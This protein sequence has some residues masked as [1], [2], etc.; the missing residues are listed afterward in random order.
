MAGKLRIAIDCRI[1]SSQQGIGT[2]V[3]ALAKALSNSGRKDQE[4]TFIVREEMKN[5]LAPSIFGCC[6]LEGVPRS[7]LST[8]KA[9]LRWAAPLRYIWGKLH[10][11]FPSIATSD[12][13]VES[14]HFD[15]V[16]F[17]TPVAYL[18]TLP[19]IYQPHDL[20]HLH[21]PEFF[22]KAQ[23]AQRER[24]YRAFCDQAFYVCVQTE[25]T[26]LDVL[27]RYHLP[28]EKVAVI[29]WG[30][31][32]DAYEEPSPEDVQAC[33][34]KFNLPHL[35]FFYPAVTWPHKNHETIFRALH[36]LKS[37]SGLT[38]HVFFTGSS[39]AYSST[40]DKLARDLGISEQLHFLGFVTSTELQT[41]FRVATAMI[42]PS[43]FEGFGLPILEAFHAQLPVLCAKTS[44]L[45]EVAQDGA[46]YFDPDSPA[47]LSTLMKSILDHPEIRQDLV[48][49]GAIVG[50]QYSFKETANKFQ[51]LYEKVASSSSQDPL[52]TLP[53][54]ARR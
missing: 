37:E 26:K 32:F 11:S 24:E 12:G 8:V 23:F 28:A 25:W 29:P 43:R 52:R 14:R 9:A 15:M 48:N 3:L 6:T 17:P 34:L 2:A 22:S 20:Q 45:P 19:T 49:K 36:I 47:E 54:A 44:T 35:F 18:T 51:A 10:S 1:T 42:Y 7:T 38:P 46:L 30:S 50:S 33:I 27:A 41:I 13:Y 53:R 31:V 16:H 4:Y 40:L 21:Y 5:W 39:T